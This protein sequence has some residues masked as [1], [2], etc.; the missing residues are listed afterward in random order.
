MKYSVFNF[1][2]LNGK[3]RWYQSEDIFC[4]VI[5]R[6]MSII[7][8][9]IW[10]FSWETDI[11]FCYFLCALNSLN[12]FLFSCWFRTINHG[13]VLI[14]TLFIECVNWMICW[15]KNVSCDLQL[16]C[17]NLYVSVFKIVCIFCMMFSLLSELKECT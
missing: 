11:A 3:S 9:I 13:L 5:K 4:H 12:N 1:F 17:V 7:I 10:L 14:F 2:F 15:S 8:I 16:S 6:K